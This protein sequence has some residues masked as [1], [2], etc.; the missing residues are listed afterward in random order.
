MNN[1][2]E[3]RKLF[4]EFEDETKKKFNYRYDKISECIKEL[5]KDR[6]NPYFRERSFI[7]FCTRLRNLASHNNNDNYYLITDE[8]V[9]KL[10]QILYEVKNPYKVYEKATINVYSNTVNDKVLLAMNKMNEENYTHIPIYEED[11]RTLAGV[12][13]ENSL[14][15]YV[16]D[17]KIIEIDDNTTFNDIRKCI[18][19]N[20]S[21]ETIIF[22]HRNELYDN[23]VND[24][25]KV[26]NEKQKL[27]YIMVTENGKQTEK[28]IGIITAW[29]VI[30]R[31]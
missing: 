13:S 4:N 20:N 9:E 10:G 22:V 31:W 29:D 3:F 15:Q 23:V 17:D 26:F 1:I 8:T 16:I 24:F 25:I 7:E 18:D 14:F 2:E 5:V 19:L 11:G 27:A 21:K 30:G 12:F 28:V 6:K